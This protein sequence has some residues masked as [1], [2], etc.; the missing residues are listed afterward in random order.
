VSSPNEENH[1]RPE[2]VSKAYSMHLV[3]LK[4]TFSPEN[5]WYRETY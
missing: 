2:R 3:I 4:Y 1:N 5:A